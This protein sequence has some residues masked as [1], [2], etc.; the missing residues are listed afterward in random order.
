MIKQTHPTLPLKGEG[1]F[2][3]VTNLVPS[4]TSQTSFSYPI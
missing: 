2:I 3:H 1:T 4:I